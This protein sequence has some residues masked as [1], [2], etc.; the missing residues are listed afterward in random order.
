MWPANLICHVPF[1]ESCLRIEALVLEN[2][3]LLEYGS[4]DASLADV[5]AA[6]ARSREGLQG[7]IPDLLFHYT[8]ASGMRGILESSRLWATHYR[9]LN[10]ASELSYG[11]NLLESLLQE[12]LAEANSELVSEFLSR[13]LRTS[14]AFDGMFDCYISCFCERDDLLNQW[15]TYAKS[16]GG[17]ALGFK[18]KEIGRRWGQLERAQDFV[19][20]RVIYDV[21]EQ[22]GLLAE[23]LDGAIK[24]LEAGAGGASVAEANNVIARFRHFLRVEVADYLVSFKHPAFAIEKEWRLCHIVAPGDEEPVSFRDGEF[25]L[26]PYV[27]LDVS[28]MAGLYHN[29][30]PLARITHGPVTNPENVRFAISRLLKSNDC[31]FVEIAGS[32]LPMRIVG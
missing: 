23:V 1:I 11:A 25:G 9:F 3:V 16:G 30:L 19:L 26:T 32:T 27:C 10:D 7:D 29:R 21:Q 22:R 18:T 2:S 13:S 28:P 8:T 20:R 6:V 17:Y 31:N 12:R 4:L 14:D 15:R 24:V 5:S